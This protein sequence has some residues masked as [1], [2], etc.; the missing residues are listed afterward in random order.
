MSRHRLG[1]PTIDLKGKN[2]KRTF[3]G[4]ASVAALT[5]TGLS[6]HASCADPRTTNQQGLLHQMAPL[7]TQRS[8]DGSHSDKRNAGDRIVGTWHVTYTGALA[9]QAF[10]QWHSDGTEWENIDYPILGGTICMGDWKAIGENN[11]RRS[12]VGWLYMDGNPSGYFTETETDEVSHDG[13]SYRGTNDAKFYDLDGN[14][15]G[16]A[17]GTAVATRIS[18][19]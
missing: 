12:H 14:V 18:P 16:E 2:M 1:S 8:N 19:P 6:A 17:T 15:T 5:L 9:G 3:I 13:N 4:A 7:F 11:V 10:I